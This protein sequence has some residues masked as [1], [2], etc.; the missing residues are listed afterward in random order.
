MHEDL[1]PMEPVEW[2][3]FFQLDAKSVAVLIGCALFLIG[4]L[5]I[6]PRWLHGRDQADFAGTAV[7]TAPGKVTAIQISPVSSGGG[8]LFNGVNL[9]FAHHEAYYALPPDSRWKPIS[10]QSV[11]VTFQ[12]GRMSKMVHITSVTPHS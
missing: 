5:A 6:L 7:Q 1:P 8:G 9:E 10:G 4:F 11:T 12:I 2:R 3:R